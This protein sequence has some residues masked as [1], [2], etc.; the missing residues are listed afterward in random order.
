ME[1]ALIAALSMLF[2]D[3]LAVLLVQAESR[4][5]GLRSGV[6][7]AAMWICGVVTNHYA[8]NTLNGH[9]LMSTV[10]VVTLVSAANIAGCILG[11]RIGKKYFPDPTEARLVQIETQLNA[12]LE[13]VSPSES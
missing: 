2:Q 13:K 11:N 1:V 9:N 5:K 7:D 12:L 8:L 4:G 6:L 10:V 3:V